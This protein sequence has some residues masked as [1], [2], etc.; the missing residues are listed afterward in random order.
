MEK[1]FRQS[2][3]AWFK[4]NG[5]STVSVGKVSHHPGGLGG[6][7]WNDPAQVEM[8]ESWD[9]R[10]LKAGPWQHPR[11]W[12][13]GLA[14]GEIRKNASEMD[15]FQSVEGEDSIYPDGGSIEVAVEQLDQLAKSD[16]PFFLAVGILRPHLPFGAPAKYFELYKNAKLP[17][18]KAY[19]KPAGKTTWHQSGEFMKYN[20]WGRNPNQDADF[21]ELVRKHYAAC[22]SYA[23]AQVGKLLLRLKESGAMDRTIIVLWGDHGWHL[24]EHAIW[25]K[26][27]LF[28]QSLR[29]P[30]IICHPQVNSA[31]IVDSV[32][33]SRDI[34]PTL[35]DLA[36]VEKPEGLNGQV[37][38][39]SEPTDLLQTGRGI[40]ISY[41]RSAKTIRTARYRLIAHDDGFLE[42]YDHKVD[43]TEEHN[44]ASIQSDL[45]Q[46]LLAA[47]NLA[48]QQK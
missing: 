42:L 1:R 23:D 37:I 40:A 6:P 45:A 38:A 32:V 34:F 20:R 47:M 30:L 31:S 33:E 36:G 13:H 25:G 12:M 2:M 27:S 39:S 24:G 18:I 41:T 22:V 11:G 26:H 21:A 43:A 5:Y 17:T 14:H 10:L 8:P 4:Q 29:S 3:P 19:K 28:E 7:D 16:T 35:C 48:W 9:T 44:V 46:E 15:V